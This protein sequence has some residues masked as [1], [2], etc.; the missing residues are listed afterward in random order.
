MARLLLI[1]DDPALHEALAG[2]ITFHFPQV[3]LISAT[4]GEVALCEI[5]KQEFDLILCD[6]A[7]PGM[8]GSQVIPQIRRTH[9]C[10]R[11]FLVTGHPHPE[12]IYRHANAT[13]FIKKPFEREAFIALL[14]ST[15][16]I[17]DREKR[18]T[19]RIRKIGEYINSLST[20]KHSDS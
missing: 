2:T 16:D 1:D 11:V 9:P 8:N 7:M 17:I 10:L 6:L 14:R 5:E 19:T 12:T 20:P 3:E 18:R 4:S 13:G 15:L